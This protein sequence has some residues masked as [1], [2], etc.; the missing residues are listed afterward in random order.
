MSNLG[1]MSTTKIKCV[2]IHLTNKYLVPFL[3]RI[4]SKTKNQIFRIHFLLSKHEESFGLKRNIILKSTNK[5]KHYVL[6]ATLN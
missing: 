5:Q 4:I 1:L 2:F 3:Y 6:D